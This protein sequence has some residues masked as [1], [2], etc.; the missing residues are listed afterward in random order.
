MGLDRNR[1]IGIHGAIDG[2]RAKQLEVG[3]TEYSVYISKSCS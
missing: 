3:W 2:H 1:D